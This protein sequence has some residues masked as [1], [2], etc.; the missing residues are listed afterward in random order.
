MMRNGFNIYNRKLLH[1]LTSGVMVNLAEKWN[2]QMDS[3]WYYLLRNNIFEKGEPTSLLLEALGKIVR[4]TLLFR[5][6][7]VISWREKKQQRWNKKK[8]TEYRDQMNVLRQSPSWGKPVSFENQYIM[9]SILT[10]LEY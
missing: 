6:I 2:R 1:L 5:L 8:N 4:K 3:I 9:L 7:K 10:L